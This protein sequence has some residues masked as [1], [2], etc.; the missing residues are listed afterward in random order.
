[1][2]ST[3]R[4]PRDGTDHALMAVLA[5]AGLVGV[6]WL[7]GVASARLSGHRNPHADAFAPIRAFG[8][9]GDPSWAW[10]SSVGPPPLYWG[11][12]ASF[13]AIL[14]VA[15]WGGFRL[16]RRDPERSPSDPTRAEGLAVRHQIVAAAGP[17]ALLARGRT[18]RPSVA[19]PQPR[20]IGYRLGSSRGVPCWGT[21]GVR[22]HRF[23][24]RRASLR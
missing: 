21:D 10:H 11:V 16:L 17:G 5:G 14:V 23:P 18:L 20:D 15:L 13:V 12:T 4:L 8:H 3:P 22:S 9:P 24:T 1:M 6:L 7:A 19:K 2:T